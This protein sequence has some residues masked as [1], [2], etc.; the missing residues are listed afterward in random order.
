[1]SKWIIK[2][3]ESKY[4]YFVTNENEPLPFGKFKG[5]S[6]KKLNELG[7]T[8]EWFVWAASNKLFGREE[9]WP[10][11]TSKTYSEIL[12]RSSAPY[13]GEQE[14]DCYADYLD[15]STFYEVMDHF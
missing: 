10:E 8:R 14:E 5:H 12:G 7:V 4:E 13:Y 9:F 15:H 6:L 2:V 11:T 1:M 3:P